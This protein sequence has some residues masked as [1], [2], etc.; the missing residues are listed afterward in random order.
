MKGLD[1]KP[2]SIFRKI[3]V[4]H[5][6]HYL[7]FGAILL[8]DPDHVDVEIIKM[9]HKYDGPEIVVGA[10]AREWLM[11]GGP[12]CTYQHLIDCV[13]EYDMEDLAD[14]IRDT[15]LKEGK[16]TY[17]TKIQHDF[18]R[19]F[20]NNFFVNEPIGTHTHHLVNCY[21]S[22]ISYPCIY[23]IIEYSEFD[24]TFTTDVS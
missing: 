17:S 2:L 14:Q 13:R 3:A 18:L 8:N 6:E 5:G 7:R 23:N 24:N 10:F 22:G 9:N 20:K 4:R 21:H 1:G 16:P 15:I 12:T 11:K 19:Q